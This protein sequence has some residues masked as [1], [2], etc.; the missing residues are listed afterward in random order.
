VFGLLCVV[1]G[2]CLV[3]RWWLGWFVCVWILFLFGVVN[4]CL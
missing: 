4:A 1:G 2:G 3:M